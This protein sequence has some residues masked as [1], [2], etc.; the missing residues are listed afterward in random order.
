M[1]ALR[2]EGVLHRRRVLICLRATNIELWR[3]I[4]RFG[5][6][7]RKFKMPMI[8][9][10]RLR[11]SSV[12]QTWTRVSPTL[13]EVFFLH[14]T[15]DFDT[16]SDIQLKKPP[17]LRSHEVFKQSY[18]R[19]YTSLLMVIDPNFGGDRA[20]FRRL[21][22]QTDQTWSKCIQTDPMRSPIPNLFRFYLLMMVYLGYNH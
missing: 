6:L 14:Y 20:K 12:A 3:T 7:P 8:F 2:A 1:S 9:F 17:D 19:S 16:D 5:I 10:W 15:H 21:S 18:T 11:P 22:V 13:L 4:F